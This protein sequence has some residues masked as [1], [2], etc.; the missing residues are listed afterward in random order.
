MGD[1]YVDE[2]EGLLT[3]EYG[4]SIETLNFKTPF[5]SQL[6]GKFVDS[7]LQTKMLDLVSLDDC[8]KYH[9]PMLEAFNTHLTKINGEIEETCPIT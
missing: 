7:I 5:Q 6:T 3:K 4:G 1:Y 2:A 8:A 9:I